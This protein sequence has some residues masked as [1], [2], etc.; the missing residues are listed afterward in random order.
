MMMTNGFGAIF[1]SWTSGII[2]D[3]FFL[4]S[5]GHYMWQGIWLTFAA[6]SLVVTILFAIFFK[7]KHDPKEVAS[8]QH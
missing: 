5:N 1:G 6:Y 8:F 7:H 3:K 2:I 4:N